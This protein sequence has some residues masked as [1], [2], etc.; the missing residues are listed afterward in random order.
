MRRERRDFQG[1]AGDSVAH[2]KKGKK[3]DKF[4]D[5]VELFQLGA[6]MSLRYH[7]KPIV[8]TYSGGKDSDVLVQVALA[9]G[10]PFEVHNNHT[11]VDAPCKSCKNIR[12]G[13]GQWK[14]ISERH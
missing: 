13:K 2:A 4:D 11:T 7:E 12:G 8:V 6:R 5:A 1:A 3:M 14:I 10:M 9:S